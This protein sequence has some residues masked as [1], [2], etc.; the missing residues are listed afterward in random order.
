[1]TE[2]P[3]PTAH[4]YAWPDADPDGVPMARVKLD[5][6]QHSFRAAAQ[7]DPAIPLDFVEQASRV[8]RAVMLHAREK[9]WIKP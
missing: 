2:R 8:M 6:G 9:G 3:Q 7:Y 5:V 4:W 1:M